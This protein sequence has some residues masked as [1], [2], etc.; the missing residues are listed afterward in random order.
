RSALL[1][2]LDPGG[3]VRLL[4]L[5]VDQ[6][7]TGQTV[8]DEVE[9]PV[10]QRVLLNDL[11]QAE[12]GVDGR[13]SLV[14]LLPAGLEQGHRDVALAVEGRARHR[15]VAGLEDMKRQEHARKEDDVREGEHRNDPR[16]TAQIGL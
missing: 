2:D 11:P 13:G 16:E 1:E 5:L 3:P 10:L 12:D 8:K 6:A 4:R 7:E 9:A 14:A 15:P